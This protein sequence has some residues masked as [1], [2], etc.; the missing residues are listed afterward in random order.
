M[1]VISAQ[2]DERPRYLEAK[3]F[4]KGLSSTRVVLYF[5]RKSAV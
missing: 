1:S 3:L 5:I 2:Y 4:C